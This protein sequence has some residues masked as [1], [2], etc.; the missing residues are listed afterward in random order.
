LV[1][2]VDIG[3]KIDVCTFDGLRIGVPNLLRLLDRRG[4]QATFFVALGPD[5][6]G[7][8]FLRILQPG[9]LAKLRRTRAVRTYG[10]RTIVSGTLLPP[11]HAGRRLAPVLRR[12]AAAGHELAIHG[13]DHRKWQD[14]VHR[15]DEGEVRAEIGRAVT[16]YQEV[17]GCLPR[18][19]GAPGWQASVASLQALDEMGFAYASDARGT[20]PF[21]PRVA[22]RALR[23]LQLPTTCPTLDEALGLDGLDGNGYVALVC[24]RLQGEARGILTLHAEMEGIG[25]QTV[26]D[27]LIA[28]LH[29]EGARCLSL[30]ILAKQV[31]AEGEQRIPVVE[32][33]PRPI[34]G[35]AGTV[36]MPAGLEI[37]FG[38]LT[39]D[40]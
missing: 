38:L 6:T 10:L 21:F 37:P 5:T 16:V 4:V 33:V 7:R 8:A 26:A 9:F 11:R 14:R 29:A 15:M 40:Y 18:G 32:V 3:L 24:R 22:G 13:Y 12:V 1:S 28:A 39:T 19:F 20:Q 23:T 30:E 17:T 31:R 2:F 36:A 35:R 25:F 27:R 34:R